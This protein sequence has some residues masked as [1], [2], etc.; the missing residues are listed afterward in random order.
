MLM[1]LSIFFSCLIMALLLIPSVS[2]ADLSGK[3]LQE[4]CKLVIGE[5][6]A[7]PKN[8]DK[9]IEQNFRAG[10]CTGY[11]KG[12]DDMHMVYA[13]VVARY[14]KSDNP[15]AFFLYCI[16]YKIHNEQLAKVVVDYI[17]KHP[18]EL[19]SPASVA[20]VKALRN[21]FPCGF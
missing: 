9:E 16:P 4:D 12:L 6:P 10:A 1:K 8:H 15:R 5:S 21:A 2:F 13:A 18:E 19:K 14:H 3:Q 17:K 7:P 20:A 11:L